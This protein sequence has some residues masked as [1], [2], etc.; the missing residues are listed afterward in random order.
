MKKLRTY[1]MQNVLNNIVT[2][3]FNMNIYYIIYLSTG[4]SLHRCGQGHLG[5]A[6]RAAGGKSNAGNRIYLN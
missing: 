1:I 5:I 3:G 6:W 2:I 4:G